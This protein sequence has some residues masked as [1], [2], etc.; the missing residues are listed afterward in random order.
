VAGRVRKQE[1]G[2][3][4]TRCRAVFGAWNKHALSCGNEAHTYNIMT[5]IM[6]VHIGWAAD[7]EPVIGAVKFLI[8]ML[9]AMSW[10]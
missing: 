5:V 3:N 8:A 10:A 2:L 1:S 6:R 4:V 7:G 9:I